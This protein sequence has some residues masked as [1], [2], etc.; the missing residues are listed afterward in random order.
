MTSKLS[1]RSLVLLLCLFGSTPACSG[2]DT[3]SL[4]Q[5]PKASA[6]A[7]GPYADAGNSS[8]DPSNGE[9][10]SS[11]ADAGPQDTGND[12]T[13]S[14]DASSV[15]SC[16]S[17]TT[18]T[19]CQSCCYAGHPAGSVYLVEQMAACECGPSGPCQ[20]ACANTLCATPLVAADAICTTCVGGN[21]T[22]QCSPVLT[23]C[24][25]EPDCG[26]VLTCLQTCAGK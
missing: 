24:E 11:S 18:V 1:L 25:T 12:V 7:G 9:A 13:V 10:D 21:I 15:P 4:P 6:T 2:S 17:A 16:A 5:G 26:A 19:A 14:D 3:D 8:S 23:N 22:G 20:S